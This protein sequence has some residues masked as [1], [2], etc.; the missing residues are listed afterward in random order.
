M[1]SAPHP[2]R[3]EAIHTHIVRNVDHVSHGKAS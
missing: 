2:R 3:C 1:L